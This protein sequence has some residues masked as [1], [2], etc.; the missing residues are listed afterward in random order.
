LARFQFKSGTFQFL[1]LSLFRLE[2]HVCLSPGVQVT[3]AVSRV[4][5]RIMAGVGD[6][7]Q[8]IGDGRTG[9]IL[10]GRTIGRSG[11]AACGLYRAR[12]D[13]EHRFLG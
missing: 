2:N 1:P 8:R 13:E 3:G 11:D 7:M 4:A 9:R 6:L 10:G 5:T 12:G